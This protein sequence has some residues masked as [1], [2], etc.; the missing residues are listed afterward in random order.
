MTGSTNTTVLAFAATLLLC[1]GIAATV[2]IIL[3]DENSLPRRWWNAHIERLQKKFDQLFI[4]TP[5]TQVA[6][7]QLGVSVV[8]LVVGLV[9]QIYALLIV[10][11]LALVAPTLAL[12]SK[13]TD[14]INKMEE[15]LAHWL[16]LLANALRATPSI[17]GSIEASAKLVPSPLREHVEI[18]VK[19]MKLGQP[20]EYA[21]QSMSRRIDS[22]TLQSAIATIIIG[23]RTGGDVPKLLEES[24]NGLREMARLE[25]LIR[26]KT[27]EGKGQLWVLAITPF[28]LAFGME[29]LKPGWFDPLFAQELGWF[30]LGVAIALWAGA[31]YW[32]NRILDIEV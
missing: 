21:L 30:L 8:A 29:Q 32:A 2:G 3:W 10:I 9:F 18:V 11:P 26:A 16:M 6:Q 12:S 20:V 13:E 5:A 14:N 1:G 23:Q 22:Q 27:A 31:I 7:A 28:A 25:G 4:D 24:S 17:P 19:E 15:Q